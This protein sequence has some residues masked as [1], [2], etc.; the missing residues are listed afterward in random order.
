MNKSI[1]G[2]MMAGS[3]GLLWAFVSPMSKIVAASGVDISTVVLSRML[4]VVPAVGLWLKFRHPEQ[5]PASW[6]ELRRMGM[7]SLLCPT[8]LYLGFML[9]LVYL[10]VATALVLH[11]T[12]PVMTTIFSSSVTGEKP[13]RSDVLCACLVTA[14]V[15]CSVLSP[16]WTL[17]TAVDIRGILWGIVA[18]F[19]LAGQTLQGRA[20]VTR[21]G[22]S[23]FAKLFY[24]H[25]FG[26][27][28]I[29]IYKV[30]FIG[31]DDLAMLT[32][33]TSS[34]IIAS[35][36]MSCLLAY[37]LYYIALK[38][39]SAPMA[40]MMASTELIGAVVMTMFATGEMPNVPQVAGCI[41]ILSA[42]AINALKSSK[43]KGP[44]AA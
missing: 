7:I 21:G 11:Y 32:P 34:M 17:D 26:L 1:L 8:G 16:D 25:V 28:W 27:V 5:L 31:W 14:G 4:V 22:M 41:L 37:V 40:S 12:F 18:V 38:Y 23:S 36:F 10:N 35:A 39:I 33:F 29:L 30:V 20:S 42:I 24:S 2:M 19:G 13:T 9:S 15:A 44:S 43:K 3:T 6:A